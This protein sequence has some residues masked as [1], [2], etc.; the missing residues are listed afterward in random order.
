MKGEMRYAKH[1]CWMYC[2]L[3]SSQLLNAQSNKNNY[4]WRFAAAAEIKFNPT[5]TAVSVNNNSGNKSGYNSEGCAIANDPLTGQVLFATDGTTV[6]DKNNTQ[7]VNGNAIGGN[8]NASTAQAAAI[9]VLPDCTNKKF[10]IFSNTA[11]STV[12]PSTAG[13]LSFSIVDMSLNGGLGQVIIKNQVLRSDVD[14]AMIVVANTATNKFWLIAKLDKAN[15]YAVIAIPTN[16]ADFAGNSKV[17]DVPPPAASGVPTLT[18]AVTLSYSPAAKKIALA[19]RNPAACV[20]TLDFNEATG[21]LGNCQ[22]IDNVAINATNNAGTSTISDC[23]WSADGTKLYAATSSA[24]NVYQYDFSQNPVK[25]TV[26]FNDAN[27]L[28]S[29]TA[30]GFKLGPDEVI[31]YRYSTLAAA[32]HKIAQPNLAG[33]L[34]QFQQN[35]LNVSAA[36]GYTYFPE[37]AVFDGAKSIDISPLNPPLFCRG[38]STILQANALSATAYAWSDGRTSSKIAVKKAGDYFCTASFFGGDCQ[39]ESNH[40]Q[41]TLFPDVQA[42]AGADQQL[43]CGKT[44]DLKASASGG[45]GSFYSYKWIPNGPSTAVWTAREAGVY[46]VEVKDGNQCR[47]TSTVTL[48]NVGPNF[49]IT[50][51]KDTVLCN[52]K[53]LLI[54]PTIIPAV[55]GLQFQWSTGETAARITVSPSNDI[56]Y[57]VMVKDPNS[58]CSDTRSINVKV[59]KTNVN[60][61]LL[62]DTALCSGKGLIIKSSK[63]DKYSWSTGSSDSVISVNKAGLYYVDYTKD[64]CTA[65]RSDTVKVLAPVQANAGSDQAIPC[66][67]TTNLLASATK[68]SGQYS[69]KWLG[70]PSSPT[71]PNVKAGIYQ[72]IVTDLI[73]K[74]ADTAA[75]KVMNNNANFSV[76]LPNDTIACY[77]QTLTLKPEISP[78][79]GNYSF[80]WSNNTGNS[81]LDV[82]AMKDTS[83]SVLI[84][85]NVS[86][87]SENRNVILNVDTAIANVIA[88]GATAFC[89]GDSVVLKSAFLA[90]SYTWSTNQTADSIIVKSSGQYSLQVRSGTCLSP[91]SAVLTVTV[92]PKPTAAFTIENT[93][94]DID[95]G[96]Y[97]E[98]KDRSVFTT[99]LRYKWSFGDG[100]SATVASP[101]HQYKAVQQFR[102]S[103]VVEEQGCKD[104]VDAVVDVTNKALTDPYDILLPEG[105]SPN[106]D[107]YNDDF[108]PLWLSAKTIHIQVFNRWGV[109]VFESRDA[110]NRWSGMDLSG[111]ACP[112]GVY[113]VVASITDKYGLKPPLLKVSPV[114][115]KR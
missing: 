36:V 34:C 70:G 48:S 102:V 10:F 42:S 93:S 18:N 104:S 112:D 64:G 32:I 76:Q 80:L 8:T 47:D 111:A 23:E 57:Q 95:E 28:L 53:T 5:T 63:A 40:V 94:P 115:L 68:G 114:L 24:V 107:T 109:L 38:D 108:A 52:R 101:S 22:L 60:L 72:V 19:M 113:A 7:M 71:Y 82:V 89:S 98:F 65:I 87:C 41:V 45:S 67:A 84:T 26:V 85:D 61:T 35:A 55:A 74:C 9:A 54:S 81:S 12:F 49:A 58:G 11:T 62:G 27:F 3:L 20:A 100:D 56:T 66:Q 25:R 106:G 14:E 59:K 15:K 46:Q 90:N 88:Q 13:T 96:A 37:T 17:Y 105:F 51:R 33:A 39:L 91:T 29:T 110:A 97:F 69:Y 77:N 99:A 103:L 44:A 1:L 2:L 73:K 78:A 31:Y 6:Y 86:G 50:L 16:P 75:V 21:A 30:G 92:K 83:V 43:A 79:T 4:T